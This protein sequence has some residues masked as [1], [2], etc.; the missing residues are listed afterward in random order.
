MI[1]EEKNL[2]YHLREG[3]LK[4]RGD[5]PYMTDFA[6]EALHVGT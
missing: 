2:K 3:M 4:I 5:I 1:T 6:G